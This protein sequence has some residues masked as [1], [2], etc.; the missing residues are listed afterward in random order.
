ML[1]FGYISDLDAG[2]GLARV[3]FPDADGIVSNWIPVSVSLSL[4]DKVSFPFFINEHVWCVMDDNLEYG[5]I[6]GA[7]YSTADDPGSL[8]NADK[9]GINFAQGLNIEYQRSTGILSISGTGQVK[10]DISDDVE[11][12]TAKKVKVIAA[13]EVDITSPLTKI[14]GNLT[15]IGTVTAGGFS[16]SASGGSGGSG[17]MQI[18]GNVQVTGDVTAGSVSLKTHIHGG[19]Q[20]GGGTSGPPV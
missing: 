17:D 19:V 9:V 7:I 16:A 3:N 11:I 10:V 5:V 18:D 6:G 15:V 14:T 2:K 4:N 12:K 8:G 13:Q 20:T 1:K